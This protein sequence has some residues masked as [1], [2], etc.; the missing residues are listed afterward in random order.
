MGQVLKL[1]SPWI[2]YYRKINALFGEDP[3]VLV[4]YD[5]EEN[6]I[7]LRV[8]GQEKADAIAE[9]LPA[10]KSFGN[11]VVKITVV[12]ANKAETKL[13]VFKKA[14]EGNPVFSYALSVDTG[15]TSNTF[16]YFVFKHRICSFFNDNLGDI[17]GN[18]NALYE[19]VAKNVFEDA[20]GILFCTDTINNDS[21]F[22]VMNDK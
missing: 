3:N 21:S 22:N 5:E 18:Y 8:T 16:N 11:V 17:N 14:F 15:M 2:E 9:I 20:D 4:Q 13:E 12:P 6:E 7:I 1:S 10:E 19:D